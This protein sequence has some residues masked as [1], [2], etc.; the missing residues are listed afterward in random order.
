MVDE[1]RK[2]S[3]PANGFQLIG[4]LQFIGDRDVIH[5]LLLAVKAVERLPDKAVLLIVELA[6]LQPQFGEYVLVDQDRADHGF[7]GFDAEKFILG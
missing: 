5:R 7:F 2:I 4:P 6:R 1:L 3:R